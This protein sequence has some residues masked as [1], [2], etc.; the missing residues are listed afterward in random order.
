MVETKITE[1]F[2]NLI[3][4]LKM[5][6]A[7]KV[8]ATIAIIVLKMLISW[9]WVV[10][11]CPVL[12]VR[13]EESLLAV[14][15]QRNIISHQGIRTKW[16]I[17]KSLSLK[18]M[19]TMAGVLKALTTNHQIISLL[20]KMALIIMVMSSQKQLRQDMEQFR[21]ALEWYVEVSKDYH[22]QELMEVLLDVQTGIKLLLL[23]IK[24]LHHPP[25]LQ[26]IQIQFMKIS[27]WTQ[28][29]SALK[30]TLFKIALKVNLQKHLK[31]CRVSTHLITARTAVL[32]WKMLV[33]QT[34]SNALHVTEN[35]MRRH[36]NAIQ[37]FVLK[38]SKQREKRLM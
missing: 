23:T 8:K 29:H 37:R 24:T 17:T 4:K 27:T 35:S 38:F 20:T 32:P 25:T 16:Q 13:Y 21:T 15:N 18:T 5:E 30:E 36:L 31:P 14:T 33:P 6:W 9:H 28:I 3:C 1:K 12:Q 19:I 7:M 22:L 10:P 2:S 11:I 26:V 34:W